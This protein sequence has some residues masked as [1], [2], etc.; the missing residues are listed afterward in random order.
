MNF[1]NY[2]KLPIA[3]Q[4]ELNKIKVHLQDIQIIDLQV[5]EDHLKIQE[6]LKDKDQ[7]HLQVI[8]PTDLQDKEDHLQVIQEQLNKDLQVKL[9][10]LHQPEISSE[11][12]I[13]S[14]V[15]RINI[16]KKEI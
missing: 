10:A 12:R 3:T 14:N 1:L 16:L 4:E 2:N 7:D 15:E 6:G 13:L 5:M 9:V 8:Q 11:T